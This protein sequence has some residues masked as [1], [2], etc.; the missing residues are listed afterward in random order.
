M[1][2]EGMTKLWYLDLSGTR[3]SDTGLAHLNGLTKLSHLQ[4]FATQASDAG[5]QELRQAVPSLR[6]IR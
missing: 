1:Y 4:L 2:L 3:V 5:V 6:I